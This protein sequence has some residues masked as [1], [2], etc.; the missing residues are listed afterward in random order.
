MGCVDKTV[1]A[2]E[3]VSSSA[4]RSS[5]E[6]TAVI[7]VS[8]CV[9][10]AVLLLLLLLLLFP[11]HSMFWAAAVATVVQLP[12]SSSRAFFVTNHPTSVPFAFFFM[13]DWRHGCTSI[14]LVFS[15][16]SP[17]YHS[18]HNGFSRGLAGDDTF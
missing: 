16:K 9:V 14:L 18:K 11:S 4:S 6:L 13:G 8:R 7:S 5:V 2:A 3:V 10:G 12:T 15:S 17:K 1:V